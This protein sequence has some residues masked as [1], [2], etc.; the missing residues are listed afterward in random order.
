[1]RDRDEL[2]VVCDQV[3]TPTWSKNLALYN[4]GNGDE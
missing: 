4:L 1:M 3:G 2:Q